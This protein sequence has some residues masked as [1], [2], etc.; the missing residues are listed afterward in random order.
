MPEMTRD[1]V[2]D[3]ATIAAVEAVK[4]VTSVASSLIEQHTKMCPMQ[5]KLQIQWWKLMALLLG[6]G[7]LGGGVGG[8][9]IEVLGHK[10]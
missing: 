3:I 9:I 4:T 2:K 8:A 5:Y 7:V 1:E 6:S 10:P